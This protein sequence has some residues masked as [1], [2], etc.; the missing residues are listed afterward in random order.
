MGKR[1]GCP[2]KSATSIKKR[3]VVTTLTTATGT[4]EPDAASGTTNNSRKCSNNTSTM[5]TTAT[6]T[7]RLLRQK[8]RRPRRS[9]VHSLELADHQRVVKQYRYSSE[10]VQSALVETLLAFP[11]HSLQATLAI[12][13][14]CNKPSVVIGTISVVLQG[15]SIYRRRREGCSF[16]A[17]I[18]SIAALPNSIQSLVTIGQSVGVTWCDQTQRLLVTGPNRLYSPLVDVDSMV[19]QLI[20][21]KLLDNSV[22]SPYTV[23][24]CIDAVQFAQYLDDCQIPERDR[25]MALVSEEE[26]ATRV[27]LAHRDHQRALSAFPTLLDVLAVVPLCEIVVEYLVLSEL[28]RGA[29]AVESKCENEQDLPWVDPL[30]NPDVKKSGDKSAGDIG[31]GA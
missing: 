18:T 12:Y 8:A 5:K 30:T 24:C 26:A 27:R 31:G 9:E 15:L 16:A 28:L 11:G 10:T 4:S 13:P 23:V 21:D 3:R 14:S 7:S 17:V 29:P 1:K 19:R 2:S 25:A 20:N 22:D 6:G